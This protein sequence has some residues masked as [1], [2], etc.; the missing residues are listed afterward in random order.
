MVSV[1]ALLGATATLICAS[2]LDIRTRRVPDRFW[3]LLS[4]L[5]VVLI[6]LRIVIDEERREYALILLPIAAILSDVYFDSEGGSILA[7]GAPVL[8]YALALSS[9]VALGVLWGEELY[10]QHLLAVPI[11]MMVFI[12]MYILDIIKGGADAKALIAL[13]ILF[14]VVPAFGGFPM[15]APGDAT[16]SVV[17]PFSFAVLIDAAILV[18]FLPLGFLVRN[19]AAREIRFPQMFLGYKIDSNADAPG[20]VWLMER[21]EDGRHVTHSRPKGDENLEEELRKLRER[22]VSRVWVT[23]K[24]PFI[25]PIM[26][27]LILATIA[28]NLMFL[29]FGL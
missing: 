5:G 22:G 3:I 26:A 6:L 28:G 20:F 4:M 16:A 29:L 25:V 17:F 9:V 8:K 15:V 19:I 13:A 14:P 11:M 1:A 21:I 18:V 12:L 7:R 10:F 23:P 24:I 27:G 2:Y